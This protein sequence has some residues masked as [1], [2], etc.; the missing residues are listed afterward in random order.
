MRAGPKSCATNAAE[1][2]S[3]ETGAKQGGPDKARPKI[4]AFG[5]AGLKS[6]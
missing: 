3:Y 4:H 5:Y 2:L 6:V 1:G